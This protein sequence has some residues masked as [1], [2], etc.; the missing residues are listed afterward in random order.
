MDAR[1]RSQQEITVESPRL[2]QW[3]TRLA[4]IYPGEGAVVTLCFL[5]NFLVVTGIMFGRNS[6]DSLFLVYFGVEYLPYMYFANAASLILCSLAY[7]TLVD[8]FERGKFLAAVS[9]LFVLTLLVSRVALLGHPRW[10]FP[11]L[12]IEA[13][14]IWYFSLMQFWT[15]VGDLFDTRQAKRL[16]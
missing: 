2:R 9:L 14:V 3:L 10:F 4:P 15:F 16:F 8:R 1:P 7:T 12:Y 6:R 13:Q 5:L 11:L